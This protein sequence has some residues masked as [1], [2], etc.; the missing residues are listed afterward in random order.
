[1]FK[2]KKELLEEKLAIKQED[3]YEKGRFLAEHN[4]S[5]EALTEY[6]TS[7]IEFF[8][9]KKELDEINE[10]ERKRVEELKKSI[11]ERPK[12]KVAKYWYDTLENFINTYEKTFIKTK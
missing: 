5:I 10:Q 6:K 4:E 1:M 12:Y 3:F 8:E 11:R 9:V 7:C 2:N